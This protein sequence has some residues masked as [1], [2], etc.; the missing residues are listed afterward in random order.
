MGDASVRSHPAARLGGVGLLPGTRRGLRYALGGRI[1]RIGGLKEKLLAAARSG[2]RTVLLPGANRATVA[3]L[4]LEVVRGLQI[5]Y[6]DAFADALP[7][8]FAARTAGGRR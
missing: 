3:E 8:V 6:V 4:P 5:I 7:H 2:V 1:L